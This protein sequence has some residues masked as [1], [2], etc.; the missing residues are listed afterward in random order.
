VDIIATIHERMKSA[1]S[2]F[3]KFRHW[4]LAIEYC[5]LSRIETAFEY[6]LNADQ[7]PIANCQLPME[8]GYRR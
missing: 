6:H 7:C 4:P 1:K 3:N 5:P 8:G 2:I